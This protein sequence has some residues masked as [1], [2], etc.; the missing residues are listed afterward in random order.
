MVPT[1]N[2]E[3]NQMLMLINEHLQKQLPPKARSLALKNYHALKGAPHPKA[4]NFKVYCWFSSRQRAAEG[5]QFWKVEGKT[6]E[7]TFV[8]YNPMVQPDYADAVCLGSSVE[9]SHNGF[10]KP[11]VQQAMR[12]KGLNAEVDR[13]TQPR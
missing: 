10:P 6:V 7:V 5:S 4:R 1:S 3:R 13:M 2:A 12:R 9:F 11:E 8:D